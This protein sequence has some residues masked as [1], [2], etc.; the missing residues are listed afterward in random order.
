MVLGIYF[1]DYARDDPL[2]VNHKG[3]A[4]GA[5]TS[6]STHLLLSPC[7]EGLQHLCGRV[8]EQREGQ[9]VFATEIEVRLLRIFANTIHFVAI[10]QERLV[11]IPQVACLRGAARGRVFGIEIEDSLAAEDSLVGYEVAVL[12][13]YGKGRNTVTDSHSSF[14]YEL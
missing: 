8:G 13:L 6:L 14:N 3:L 7:A 9:F 1:V 10:R 11:V 12:V 5:Y 4:Q 2:L